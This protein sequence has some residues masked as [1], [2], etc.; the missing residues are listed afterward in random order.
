MSKKAWILQVKWET[1]FLG[2]VPVAEAS[3]VNACV[4]E[5]ASGLFR[6]NENRIFPSL[7]IAVNPVALFYRCVWSDF[8]FPF[9]RKKI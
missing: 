1:H 4:W 3:T 8:V 6:A 9:S 7:H 2:I 5:N